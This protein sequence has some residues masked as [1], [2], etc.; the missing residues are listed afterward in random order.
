MIQKIKMLLS[1]HSSNLSLTELAIMQLLVRTAYD[2]FALMDCWFYT[3]R[4]ISL[5]QQK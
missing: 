2:H 5:L 4:E 1:Y 3:N